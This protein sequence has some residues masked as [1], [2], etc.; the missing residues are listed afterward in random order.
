MSLRSKQDL[1]LVSGQFKKKTW[2]VSMSSKLEPTIWSHNTGQRITCIDRCQLTITWM[3]IIKEIQYKGTCLSQP[4]IHALYRP[5]LAR[6]CRCRAYAP[7]SNAASH[8]N[9]EKI[10]SWV[11][12]SPL[13][14]YLSPLGGLSGCRSSTIN[15]HFRRFFSSFSGN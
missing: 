15:L 3:S 13:Y 14:R 6:L 11:S 12:L 8:E 5:H 10:N 4:N 1:Y 2:Q 9:H 7:T